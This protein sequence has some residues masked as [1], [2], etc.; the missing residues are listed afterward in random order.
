M[1]KNNQCLIAQTHRTLTWL[2]RIRFSSSLHTSSTLKTFQFIC[3]GKVGAGPKH[4]QFSALRFVLIRYRTRSSLITLLVPTPKTGLYHNAEKNR[5]K[6]E[7]E[8]I[9]TIIKLEC[10][11]WTQQQHSPVLSLCL[12]SVG[13]IQ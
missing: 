6:F 5:G 4:A 9:F 1:I 12:S 13:P 10:F 11:T 2:T 7:L 8:D 3:N